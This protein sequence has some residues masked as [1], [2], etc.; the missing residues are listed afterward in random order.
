MLA[1]ELMT[2]ALKAVNDTKP[3][4]LVHLSFYII[5]HVINHNMYF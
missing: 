3:N 2:E 4:A 1:A 5:R